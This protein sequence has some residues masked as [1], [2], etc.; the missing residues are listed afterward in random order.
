MKEHTVSLKWSL[1]NELILEENSLRDIKSNEVLVKVISCGICGSDLKI[2]KHGNPRLGQGRIMGHEIAGEIIQV[3]PNVNVFKIGDKV[4]IGA[5]IPCQECGACKTKHNK[6]ENNLAF[7]HEI[8]GGFSK[9]MF[10]N[11]DHLE[12]GPIEKFE[13]L[14]FDLASLAEPLACCINGYE[15]VNFMPYESVLILGGGT[16]GMMLSFLATLHKIP[17]IYIADIANER[18]ENFKQFDF[19]TKSFNLRDENIFNWKEKNNSFDLIFTANNNP[20][21]Q[22]QAVD[23]IDS[24][25][26]INFFGGLPKDQ[27]EVEINTNKIHYKEAIVTGSHG[28]TPKQHK[29]A[30]D[31]IINNASFFEKLISKKFPLKDYKKAFKE[32]SNPSNFKIILN[33][34]S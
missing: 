9:Y 11:N 16:I 27:S 13:G 3:G 28:S 5:D 21:S 15:K 34:N 6:C 7:G 10:L 22:K 1:N 18:I 30:V 12:N 31:I 25:G 20:I 33:P 26:V 29:E 2:L 19:L 17:N 4:S 32:A 23:L 24:R 14:N 8:D